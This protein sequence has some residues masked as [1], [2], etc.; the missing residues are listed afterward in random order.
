MEREAENP[1]PGVARESRIER[2]KKRDGRVVPFQIAKV[3]D[4]VA[5]SLA[6][7]GT[8]DPT[9][10]GEVACVVELSL[11]DQARMHRGTEPFVPHI[12]EIQDL[13]ERALMELDRPAAAKSFILYR[14]QRRQV[15]EAVRV[16]K[17]ASARAPRVRESQGVS[18]WN[19]SKL[20]VALMEEAE[21]ARETAEEIAH[22]VERRVFASGQKRI[23]TGLI[24]ELVTGELL[25]RG[26]A[27]A[28]TALSALG[29][30]RHDLL[31][32]FAG[33]PLEPWETQA[34]FEPAGT[35]APEHEGRRAL[36]ERVAS[37]VL[38]RFALEEL[39]PGEVGEFHRSGDLHV[40]DLGAPHLALSLC[41]DASL[42]AS[43]G[44]PVSS[45]YAVLDGIAELAGS[46][47]RVLVLERPAEVL[48]PLMRSVRAGSPL[49]LP[50]WFA[51]LS[52][53]ARA[54]GIRVDL[55]SSG[56]RP[57]GFT[58]RCLEALAETGAGPFASR[59][60][61]EGHE[62][63][64]LLKEHANLESVVE[65][66]F[67]EGRLFSTWGEPEEFFAG[68]GCHRRARE[69]GILCCGGAIALNLPRL[70]RR[71]GPW[72]EDLVQS[73]AVELV[74]AAVEAA[75]A[76]QAF[77]RSLDAR[78]PSGIHVRRS[79]AIVP[80]GLREALLTLGEGEIDVDQGARLLG[81]LSE[82]ARRFA[83][84]RGLSCPVSPFFG[85]RA[86][87]RFAWLDRRAARAEG[88]EQGAL[89][90]EE[91]PATLPSTPYGSSLRFSPLPH[92]A[93]GRAEADGLR[94]LTAGAL[95]FVGLPGLRESA[96]ALPHLGAWRRFEVLRRA[97]S[98]ELVLE[99][100]PAP[101][102]APDVPNPPV[103]P[104]RPRA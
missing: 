19:R 6:S 24:R 101:A 1:R 39:L 77:Q 68:P 65:D 31:R 56:V 62:L 17:D 92:S 85:E 75:S 25:E 28:S 48:S 80:V 90:L 91:D 87:R 63:E 37:E 20:V 10:A 32:L 66:L 2:V 21:L 84:E 35:D 16:H 5:K 38:Q 61:L 67:A 73:A 88:G 103:P 54:R 102:R 3:R 27:R 14:E 97:R 98:G 26:L 36:G 8:P 89:F 78:R 47:S 100:F 52:A 33:A 104:L 55:G 72:R 13:V 57:T 96:E 81:L 43:G 45:A 59:L 71:A 23:T 74:Q 49:G 7:V 70:A 83:R 15:R 42:F 60:F 12:E 94:T 86:A 29:I 64:A 30:P 99:L 93:S 34:A 50:S 9:F 51:A 46:V 82:A 4:A 41:V 44:N 76:L 18:P 58:L 53:I 69:Q 95:S 11:I 22:A 79:Y 40:E